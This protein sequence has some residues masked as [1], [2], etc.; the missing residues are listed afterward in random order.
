MLH[1]G[2]GSFK[3]IPTAH[4]C[5]I[6]PA[7]KWLMNMTARRNALQCDADEDKP[8]CSILQGVSEQLTRQL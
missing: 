2:D 8:A 3:T 1:N 7:P 6:P 5:D 4:K